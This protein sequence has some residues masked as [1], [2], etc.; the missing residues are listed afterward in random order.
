VSHH[1]DTP[2]AAQTGQLYIDDLY[3]FPGTNSTVMVMNVNS[4][5][6]GMHS[7]PSFH[8]QARYELKVHVNGSTFEEI[9]YRL[10][11]GGADANG[12]QAFQLHALSGREARVDSATGQPLLVGQTGTEATGPGVRAWAGRSG[13]P[14]YIDLSLL[15]IVNA[16]LR[17]GSALD[18]SKWDPSDARNSFD[19]TTVDSIVLAVS[20]EHPLLRPGSQ[21]GVWCTTKLATDAGGWR[22]VNRGGHP[23]MW[24]IFWPDDTQFTNPAN[25]RHP[26]EDSAAVG[27]VIAD[28]V[29]STVAA[30]G[31][32]GDPESY[33]QTVARELFPDVLPYVVGRPA[34]YG[35]AV[36]NG[37]TLADN[38]PEAMLSLVVN[39]AVPS[40]LKPSVSEHLRSGQFPYVVPA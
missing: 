10:A 36:R 19:N 38:T 35:F 29:A 17:S 40:G 24:P 15:S 33:G 37:R 1:L 34:V 14:F 6:N 21:L 8:P 30:T 25:T 23:M 5:V 13:D 4:N 27:K 16:A 22:Q 2:L 26:S 39:T 31:T 18:L 9:T 28:L 32:S 20:Y 12:R 11:F 3:V 7:E